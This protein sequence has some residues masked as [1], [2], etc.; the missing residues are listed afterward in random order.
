[1]DI[2][3]A[4][5]F[6]AVASEGSLVAAAQRLHLTQTAVS[7]RLR[8]LEQQLGRPLFVRNKAGARL[9]LA[10]ER[11]IG[12]ADLLVQGWERACRQV[13]LPSGRADDIAIG[14]EQAIW[15]PLLADWLTWMHRAHPG[16]AVRV[17]LGAPE[18]LLEGVAAGT[19]DL[20]VLYNPVP[21]PGMVCELL[22]EETLV[23][24]SSAADGELDPQAFIEVD[25]G[26]V[27][28]AN[29]RAAFPEL[30][31]PPV[32]IS[33]GPLALQHLLEVGGAG[34]FRA[35]A[36]AHLL[37]TGDLRRVQ[38]APEFAHAACA[39]SCGAER[40]PGPGRRTRE[41]APHREAAS[42]WGACCNAGGRDRHRPACRGLPVAAGLMTLRCSSRALFAC[43][44]G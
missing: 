9:T 34:Y 35:S 31:H 44:L 20:A 18:S 39:G 7:A 23:M 42:N 33:Y 11:F 1:M 2:A 16:I 17:E 26:P 40:E 19:L 5:T 13:R 4:R 41:V 14:A 15:Q 29:L 38:G 21:R 8:T 30:G 36:V 10:G 24:V 25:W 3:L 12:H 32:A 22:S 6:L 37:A 43:H 27:F 28:A